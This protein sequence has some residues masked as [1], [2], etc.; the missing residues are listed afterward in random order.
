MNIQPLYIGQVNGRPVR[1][2]RAPNGVIALPWHSMTDLVSATGMPSE[3][4]IVFLDMTSTGQW[5]DD[6]RT[7]QTDT[8]P[9]LIAPHWMAQGAIG[10]FEQNGMA[11]AGFDEAYSLALTEACCVLQDGMTPEEKITN[12]IKMGRH[13]LGREDDA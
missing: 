12:I 7:V 5:Q 6:V 11:P 9:L 1:F 3:A 4:Q 8:G 10:A 2:Y 13:H